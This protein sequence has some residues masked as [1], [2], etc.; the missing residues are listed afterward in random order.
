MKIIIAGSRDITDY[1]WLYDAIKNSQLPITCV[2]SGGARGVDGLAQTW[3]AAH[4]I[5]C[6]VI[7]AEWKKHGK[8]AGYKRNTEM[9]EK[10]DGLIALYDGESKGA[11]HMIDIAYKEA[12]KRKFLIYTETLK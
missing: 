2:I 6:E 5:P 1:G 4:N 3:A 8:G 7:P 9:L 10:A 12:K 11:K